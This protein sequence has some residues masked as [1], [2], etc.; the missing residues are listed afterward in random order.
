MVFTVEESLNYKTCIQFY[1]KKF[2]KPPNLQSKSVVRVCDVWR[3]LITKGFIS[4][5]ENLKFYYIHDGKKKLDIFIGFYLEHLLLFGS[6]KD[7]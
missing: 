2:Y 4:K 1:F 7:F 3:S 6:G 5:K